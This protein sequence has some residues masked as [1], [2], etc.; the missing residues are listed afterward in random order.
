MTKIVI[1]QCFGGYG[2]SRAAYEFL[3]LPWDG[4]GNAFDRDRANPDLVCC[5][6][7]LGSAASGICA[8][9]KVVEIPD[10]V[11]WQ[12]DEYDGSES[13]HEGH[14]SWP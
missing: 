5:V 13:I 2:L 14:R 1:N 10:D 4:F 3:G 9:L 11:G 12:I 8:D 7:T 6:E